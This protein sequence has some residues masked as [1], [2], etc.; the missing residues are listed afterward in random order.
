M[1][2]FMEFTVKSGRTVFINREMITDFS[3][4]QNEDITIVSFPG[5]SDNYL[6]LKGD[7]T[8]NILRGWTEPPK[9]V[10]DGN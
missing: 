7:Q 6:Q 9:E 1:A 3:Y 2:D 10:H 8:E 4:N 5:V